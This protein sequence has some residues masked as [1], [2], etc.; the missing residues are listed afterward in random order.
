MFRS[1]FKIIFPIIISLLIFAMISC[2]NEQMRD[3]VEIKVSDPVA[4]TFIINSGAPTSSRTVI[5]NS[6]VIKE[7]DALEMRFR[8]EGYT[9]SDWEPYSNTKSWNLSFLDGVKTVYAEYRDEGHHVVSMENTITL[10]TGAPAGNFYIYGNGLI[11]NPAEDNQHE[12]TN[13]ASVKLCMNITNVLSMR[14]SNTA[15][16][17]SDA[18]WDAV[19]PSIPFTNEYD[20]IL[21]GGDG[22]KTVYAQ[23]VTNAGTAAYSTN[24]AVDGHQPYLDTTAPAATNVQ[25]NGGAANAT[26]IS[27]TLTYDFTETVFD[28]EHKMWAEYRND[29]GSWSAKEAVSPGAISKNW[30]LRSEIGTRTVYVRL[31]DIAGN[32]SSEFSDNIY[33]DTAAPPVPSPTTATPTNDTTPTWTW[34]AVPGAVNYRYYFPDYP[35]IELGNVTSFT[36][37]SPL[38][39]NQ[40]HTFYLQACDAAGNWSDFGFHTVTIDTIPPS[41]PI[42]DSSQTS[43]PTNNRRPQWAWDSGGGGNHVFRYKLDDSDLDTGATTTSITYYFPVSDLSQGTHTLYVQERDDAGNWSDTYSSSIQIIYAYSLSVTNDGHG[44][45][46]PSGTISVNHGVSTSISATPASG[47]YSFVNWT[48]TSGSA[49]ISNPASSSTTISLTSGDA[50]VQANFI[51]YLDAGLQVYYKFSGNANDSSGNNIHASVYG[52]AGL[53]TDRFNSANSAYIF[54]GIDSYIGNATQ[55]FTTTSN[56][57]VSFWVYTDV[58]A[59]SLSY[60]IN[61]ND[62]GIAQRQGSPYISLAISTPSTSSA[63]AA[64]TTGTW[65]HITGTYDGTDIKI[66]LNGALNATTNHPGTISNSGRSLELGRSFSS[67]PLYWAGKIDSF[68]IYNRTLSAAEISALYSLVD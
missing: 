41:T 3:L 35:L 59:A 7:E 25:I 2:P 47:D 36:P 54:D 63:A 8:N 53:T 11:D 20:W 65:Y 60:F 18:A 38:Y 68:R 13:T 40:D 30:I 15:V 10:N 61:C 48:V 19:T 49:F 66:Y 67:P 39:D 17:N 50:A 29:G 9:W 23:F 21:P 6:V 12:Y 42:L 14:F 56:V 51:H 45:T 58:Q 31:S 57:T 64:I 62:F 34:T 32:I 22:E 52:G 46:S 16:A 37:D 55:D 24:S 4:D 33:L 26:S 43:S 5:L 44:T 28:A 27:V 1:S